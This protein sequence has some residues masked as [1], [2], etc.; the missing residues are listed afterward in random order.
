[1]ADDV[2]VDA[3]ALGQH[4]KLF[5]RVED[6]R[7][8]ELVPEFRVE[9]FAVAVLPRRAWFDVQGLR[10]RTGE[11]FPQVLGHE[12]RTVVQAQMLRY[13]LRYHDIGQ[14]RDHYGELQRRSAWISRHSRVYSSIR[15][16]MRTLLPSCVH[17]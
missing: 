4:A 9:R 7:V 3:P 17:S 16:R 8:E 13:D 15:L 12:L 5:D 14:R 1:V 11:P 10:A 2:V 6:L